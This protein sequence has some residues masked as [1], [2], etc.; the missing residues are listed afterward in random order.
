[1]CK[2]GNDGQNLSCEIAQ[3]FAEELEQLELSVSEIARRMGQPHQRIR[4][5]LRARTRLP[6]DLLALAVGLGVDVNYILTGV[7]TP[8]PK[9]QAERKLIDHYRSSSKQNKDHLRN[10]WR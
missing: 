6:T 7:R 2:Q 1:M 5:V 3:R 8:A 4:D 10:D 9:T